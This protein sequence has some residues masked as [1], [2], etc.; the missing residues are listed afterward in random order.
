MFQNSLPSD[1][2]P[3]GAALFCP[4]NV[5]RRVVF[6]QDS[7]G[8]TKRCSEFRLTSERATEQVRCRRSE[9]SAGGVTCFHL[10]AGSSPPLLPESQV[11]NER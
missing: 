11:T 4:V 5:A 10:S 7:G 3:C 1:G 9:S 8:V 2:P 6:L